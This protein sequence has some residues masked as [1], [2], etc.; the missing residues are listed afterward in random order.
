MANPPIGHAALRHGRISMPGADYFLTLC[1][2]QK[3]PGLTQ[4]HVAQRIMD[5]L[6]TMQ[7]DTTCDVRCLT[8]M[9]DHLHLL[10]T[11]GTRLSLAKAIN[12]L[13]AKTSASLGA[14]HL[15]WERG[16]FDHRVR[17]DEDRASIFHYIYL[18]PYRASLCTPAATWPWFHCCDAD[19]AWF[20]PRLDNNLP[21]PTWLA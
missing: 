13:K 6:Q 18:N 10:L 11:L 15:S 8:V 1:T 7:T 16:Y 20:E 2:D 5:E 12:R 14:H 17:P 3:Q 19:R 9:P 21:P 4:P